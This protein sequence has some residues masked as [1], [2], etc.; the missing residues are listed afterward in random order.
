MGPAAVE[1]K[2]IAFQAL[3]RSAFDSA[4]LFL[5]TAPCLKGI[6]FQQH[7]F[8]IGASFINCGMDIRFSHRVAAGYSRLLARASPH[9]SHDMG[10]GVAG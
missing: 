2:S 3:S 7:D 4:L 9:H 6:L 8:D 5:F 10:D 1:S